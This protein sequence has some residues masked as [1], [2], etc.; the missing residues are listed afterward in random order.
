MIPYIRSLL[1][2][3]KKKNPNFIFSG[4]KENLAFH[5]FDRVSFSPFFSCSNLNELSEQGLG[6]QQTA[7]EWISHGGPGPRSAPLC[8]EQALVCALSTPRS[9]PRDLWPQ[10]CTTPFTLEKRR[11]HTTAITAISDPDHGVF[12]FYMKSQKGCI[13]A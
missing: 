4:G 11:F 12:P 3:K 9:R 5:L 2:K 7:F 13:L 1:L 10:S 6:L 8:T